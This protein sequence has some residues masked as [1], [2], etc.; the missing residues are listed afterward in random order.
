MTQ[1]LISDIQQLLIVEK[2]TNIK[3]E[4]QRLIDTKEMN[5]QLTV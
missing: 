5:L 3:A 4:L 2:N 1:I